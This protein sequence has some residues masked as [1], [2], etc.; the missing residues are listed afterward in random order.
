MS[1]LRLGHQPI[2]LVVYLAGDTDFVQNIDAQ[3]TWPDGTELTLL[4]GAGAQTVEWAATVEGARASW[5]VPADQ[6]RA[7]VGDG[8]YTRAARLRYSHAAAPGILMWA[9]GR[10]QRG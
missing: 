8:E 9:R 4:I 7:L 2:A 10:V 6:V 1:G 5:Y 3:P